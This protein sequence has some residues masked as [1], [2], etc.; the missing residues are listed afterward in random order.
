MAY[1]RIGTASSKASPP[2]ISQLY[3]NSHSNGQH[4]G[5]D[6]FEKI[7]ETKNQKMTILSKEIWEILI[8]KQMMIT[9]E[10][11]LSLL[12]KVTNLESLCKVDSSQQVLCRHVF[13]NL[14]LKLGTPT[15]GFFAS[16]VSYQ[17]AQYVAW[18][19]DPCS[20]AKGVLSIPWTQ[21]HCYA[22][23]LFCLIPRVLSK[24]QQDQVH[25]ITLITPC[26]ETQFCYPQV[27]GMLITRQIVIRSSTTLLVGPKENSY[28]LVLNK[29]L[30]LVTWQVS[31]KD[32]LSREFPRKQPSLLP[33]QE[34][35]VLWEMTNWPGKSGLASVTHGK[36]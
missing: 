13:R 35:K 6:I 17:V 8:S 2:D 34:G 1:Q 7:R 36:F 23:P 30:I 19:P 16:W 31:G 22:F 14:C 21:G 11:L 4:S 3:F 25:T 5:F 29:T 18:K 20:I 32:Y 9:V 26:W 27:L 28:P 12:N 10:Y 24:T 15:V 33:S